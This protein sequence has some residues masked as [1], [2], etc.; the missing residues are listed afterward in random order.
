[1]EISKLA[2]TDNKRSTMAKMRLSDLLER[3]LNE[4]MAQDPLKMFE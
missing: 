4:L 2:T 1:M 3:L